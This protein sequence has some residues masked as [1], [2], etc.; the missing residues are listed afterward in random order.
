MLDVVRD[1]DVSDWEPACSGIVQWMATA[2][3]C[4]ATFVISFYFCACDVQR[5]SFV[6]VLCHIPP[7]A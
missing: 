6:Y 7:G 2:D 3:A 5:A 1:G 4:F